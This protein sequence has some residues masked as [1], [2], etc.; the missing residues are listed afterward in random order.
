MSKPELEFL[1]YFFIVFHSLLVLFNLF[2]WM[3]RKT[4]RLNFATITI[5]LMSWGI[6]GIWYGFGYCPLTDWHYDILGQLGETNLPRSYIA[7]LVERYTGW[8]PEAGL[9]DTLTGIGIVL[10]L[11][12]SVWVNFVRKERNVRV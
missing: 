6:L 2:G 7:F 11:I 9:V 12:C 1:N 5:T 3:F 10:A 8:L 4:R